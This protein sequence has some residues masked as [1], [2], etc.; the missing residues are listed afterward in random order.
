[1]LQRLS[2]MPATIVLPLM[3]Y[4]FIHRMAKDFLKCLLASSN[5]AYIQALQSVSVALQ[6]ARAHSIAVAREFL[7]LDGPP[8]LP[9]TAASTSPSLPA[10]LVVPR[11]YAAR[12]LLDIFQQFLGSRALL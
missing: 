7:T 6:S 1:M 4:S 12:P 11:F 3:M 2:P 5:V 8:T 10:R 9:Y